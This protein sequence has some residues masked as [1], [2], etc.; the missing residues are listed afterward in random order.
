M[1]HVFIMTY[2]SKKG[3]MNVISF[4]EINYFTEKNW[5][6]KSQC[7]VDSEGII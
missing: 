3:K 4:F 6:D 1:V 2:V 5:V 7:K